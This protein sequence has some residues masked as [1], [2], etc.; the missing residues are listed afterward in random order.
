MHSHLFDGML[1]RCA[2]YDICRQSRSLRQARW[3]ALPQQCCSV[4]SIQTSVA[5]DSADD[6]FAAALGRHVP[7]YHTH[8]TVRW[9]GTSHRRNSHLVIVAPW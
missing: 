4:G 1:W 9:G 8:P 3:N 5:V 6:L 2:G 7:I